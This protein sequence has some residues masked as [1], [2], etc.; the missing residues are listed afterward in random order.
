MRELQHEMLVFPLGK[1]DDVIDA[2]SMHTEFWKTTRAEEEDAKPKYDSHSVEG[3]MEEL[4]AAR[5][6]RSSDVFA[7]VLQQRDLDLFGA[8]DDVL[9]AS[10]TNRHSSR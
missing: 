6:A 5:T 9:Q 7:G 2:L 10:S 3:V 1:H 8:Y 4:R